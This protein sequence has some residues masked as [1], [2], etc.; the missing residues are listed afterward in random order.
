MRKA[1][2]ALMCVLVGVP[3]T[4]AT[5]R[6]TEARDL[7]TTVTCN[8]GFRFRF[9][10]ECNKANVLSE[11]EDKRDTAT[12]NG[13]T[14]RAARY[15]NCI[16]DVNSGALDIDAECAE[17]KAAVSLT[18]AFEQADDEFSLDIPAFF[19]GDTELNTNTGPLECDALLIP[20]VHRRSAERAI[21]ESP[22]TCE[23]P[24]IMCT[25][26]RDRQ[27]RDNNGDCATPL[28]KNCVKKGPGDNT[29]LCMIADDTEGSIHA[30]GLVFH[31]DTPEAEFAGNMLFFVSLFDHM[32]QRGYVENVHYKKDDGTEYIYPMCGCL[33]DMPKVSRSDCTEISVRRDR[34]TIRFSTGSGLSVKRDLR[35]N[36]D[37]CDGK[38][39][40][41]NENNSGGNDN[42]LYSELVAVY[43]GEGNLP[44]FVGEDNLVGACSTDDVIEGLSG[45]A[46]DQPGATLPFPAA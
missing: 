15:Q 9:D 17:A 46:V 41:G 34:Y 24:I 38:D 23:D 19:R 1:A 10:E 12:D 45:R 40:D 5:L 44:E 2:I 36:F 20:D 31:P 22:I 26:I 6:A 39:E 21:I 33:S 13:Q 4:S 11:L 43:G 27:P 37:A 29:D 3:L 7:Q 18:E 25:W 16:N 28:H 30:H 8:V 42:D 32:Y 35:V 14:G